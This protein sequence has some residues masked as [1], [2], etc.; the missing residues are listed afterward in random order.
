MMR[1]QKLMNVLHENDFGYVAKCTC[2]RDLKISLGNAILTFTEDEYVGFDSF[3]NEIRKVFDTENHQKLYH[4]NFMIK[5]NSHGLVL[6]FSYQ[7]LK[8]TIELFDFANI[9]LSVHKL[10]TVYEK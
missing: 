10:T 8:N 9:M 5:A 3:L 4:Q 6:S 7:E 2:Y 1:K